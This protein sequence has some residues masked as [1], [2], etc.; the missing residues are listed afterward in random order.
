MQQKST[1]VWISILFIVAVAALIAGYL[2]GTNRPV[3]SGPVSTPQSS[4]SPTISP[5]TQQPEATPIVAPNPEEGVAC[6]MDVKLCP[7]GSAVGRSGPN[8][9]FDPCPGESR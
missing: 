6:T 5:A 4:I 8:C 1:L 7:D 9:E 3:N 2:L